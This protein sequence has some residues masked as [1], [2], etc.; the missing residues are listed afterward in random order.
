MR[1]LLADAE[2]GDLAFGGDS[3]STAGVEEWIRQQMPETLGRLIK[4]TYEAPAGAGTT[5]VE[6]P[7]NEL[8]RDLVAHMAEQKVAAVKDLAQLLN[9]SV[10]EIEA[11]VRENPESF[12]LAAGAE[13]VVFERIPVESGA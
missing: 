10:Q 13:A 1:R 4:E 2:S 12:V 7:V 9:R 3:V 8:F 5:V 6:P 11:C